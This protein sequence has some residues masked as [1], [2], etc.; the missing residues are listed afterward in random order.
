MVEVEFVDPVCSVPWEAIVPLVTKAHLS[1]LEDKNRACLRMEIW[2]VTLACDLADLVIFVFCV[3]SYPWGV[4]HGHT[5]HDD[6][7]YVVVGQGEAEGTPVVS[8]VVEVSH[9][10]AHVVLSFQQLV[11]HVSHQD[12][13]CLQETHGQGVM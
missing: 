5:F 8:G 1:H 10:L 9:A 4:S 13:L 3:H 12:V 7:A 6:Q 11:D 2:N